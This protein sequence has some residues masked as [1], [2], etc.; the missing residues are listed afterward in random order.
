MAMTNLFERL[1]KERPSSSSTRKARQLEGA[2][3]LLNWL[4]RW[5]K[6]TIT[7]REIRIFGPYALRD[8]K[9]AILDAAEKL[10][11][12]GWLIPRP[13]RKYHHYEWQIVR[14]NT[15]DPAITA[16]S[17]L[18]LHQLRTLPWREQRKI[19]KNRPKAHLIVAG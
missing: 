10:V 11:M 9:R 15:L 12:N 5:S 8:R 3:K 14:R 16:D 1:S 2:Q 7:A 17:P 4:M 13:A 19:L 6:D 18:T